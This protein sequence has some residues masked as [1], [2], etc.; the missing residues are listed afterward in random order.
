MNLVETVE[1]H[2][3]YSDI[4]TDGYKT[5]QVIDASKMETNMDLIL[6]PSATA[7]KKLK[8]LKNQ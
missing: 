8:R 1:D 2:N 7:M 5:N 6:S 3:L 4:E